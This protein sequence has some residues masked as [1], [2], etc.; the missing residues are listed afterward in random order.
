MSHAM[1]GHGRLWKFGVCG[2][3]SNDDD[4][5]DEVDNNNDDDDANDKIVELEL[6]GVGLKKVFIGKTTRKITGVNAI[7]I[8][9]IHTRRKR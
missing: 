3:D 9:T 2:N 1:R 4:D 8:N 6:Q 5:D 7:R